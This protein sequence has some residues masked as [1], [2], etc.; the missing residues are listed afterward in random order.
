MRQG[1]PRA[2]GGVWRPDEEDRR[3]RAEREAL[4]REAE[5]SGWDERVRFR[6]EVCGEAIPPSG[7]C[8][9][10]CVNRGSGKAGGREA[11][12]FCGDC[13]GDALT[14]PDWLDR[15]NMRDLRC[16]AAE[17]EGWELLGR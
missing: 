16:P 5:G 2:S 17:S 9:T 14:L 6:C 15:L 8:L 1:K 7:D 4:I 3:G 11:L 13:A 12:R 10:V